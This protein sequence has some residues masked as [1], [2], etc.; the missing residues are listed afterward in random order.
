MCGITGFLGQGSSD[1]LEAMTKALERR[2]PDDQGLLFKDRLGLG[3]RRL[4]VIDPSPAGRQP[5]SASTGEVVVVFNGEIYNFVPLKAD[6]IKRGYQFNNQTDTE[7]ILNG[8]LAFGTDIFPKLEGMF[9]LALYDYRSHELVLVRDRLGKKPLYWSVIGETLLFGS[10]LKSLIKHPLFNRSLNIDALTSYLLF[11]YV[12]GS[13]SIWQGVYKLNPGHYLKYKFGQQ[14]EI[15]PFWSPDLKTENITLPEALAQLESKLEQSVT[16]RLVADVPLGLFLS[17]G[18]D[19]STIAYYASKVSGRPLQAFSIAF[20]DQS[21]DESDYAKKLARQLGLK[22]HIFPLTGDG[23]LNLIPQVASFLDEP[24]ADSSILPTYFLSLETKK[25]ITVALSGDGGDELFAGYPTFKVEQLAC[26]LALLPGEFRSILYRAA[27]HWPAN[28]DYFSFDFKL[29]K[30][31]GGLVGSNNPWE[32]HSRWLGSF[33]PDNISQLLTTD[34]TDKI[35]W[36]KITSQLAG[37][38]PMGAPIDQLN[39]LLVFY[40]KTYL[41]DQVLVKVDRAS[42]AAGLEVRSPL[43]DY[44][45]VEW[46]NNLPANL[47]LKNGNGKFLLKKLM[48][49]KIPDELIDRPKQGFAVP[50]ARWLNHEL[51]DLVVEKLS[52][53][54]LKQQGIFKPEFVLRLLTEHQTGRRNNAKLIWNLLAFQLWY[55]QWAN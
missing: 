53:G 43:L 20:T 32:R 1:I 50:M 6:L 10:E 11:D 14:P 44:R 45:L 17:G 35:N 55:D 46:A 52:A 37:K 30:F 8:Y 48:R 49:G 5:M 29:K 27:L 13:D 19:S 41:T 21:F 34:Q 22:H 42:M 4:S 33:T 28:F 16:N 9:A 31:L 54:Y 23:C 15:K 18:L 47:K 25:H 7:V 2:G 40:Q 24:L 39:K 51:K 12:P 26:L 3:H 38:Y 36:S